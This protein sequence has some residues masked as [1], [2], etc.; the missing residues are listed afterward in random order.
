MSGTNG[1]TAGM[2]RCPSGMRKLILLICLLLPSFASPSAAQ[3]RVEHRSILELLFGRPQPQP[4]ETQ[5]DEPQQR[6][7][8]PHRHTVTRLQQAVA[9]PDDQPAAAEKLATAKTILVV[10]D[11]LANGLG[12]GLVDAFSASPGVAVQTRGT[13]AS[14]LVRPDFYDW[15]A[16]LPQ[17]MDSLKPAVVVVMIGAN[18]RQRMTAPGIDE[19]FGTDIWLLAYEERVQALAKLVTARH[20]PLLWIGL[21]PFGSD[22][23]TADI[24]RLNQLYKSQA[25]AVGGEYIDIWDGFTDEDGKFIVTGSD[26]NGQQV[27]LRTADGINMTPAGRRKMAFYAEKPLRRLLGDQAS[28]DITRLDTDKTAEPAASTSEKADDAATHTVP[29]GLSDPDLDG[30]STLLGSAPPAPPATPS[31][32]DLLVEK[33]E[34]APAPAG[35]VD[36]FRLPANS[37]EKTQ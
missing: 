17:M 22:D 33:G 10:G 4:N 37:S 28:P 25:E 20:I 34:V 23:T 31:P 7:P 26:I 11:F 8:R 5:R 15:Q 13:I 35:R 1:K 3:Q 2:A 9:T 14:G 24:V 19:K 6:A 21:P 27:R 29:I 36:D 32:R 30:G 16:T 18:D 12:S